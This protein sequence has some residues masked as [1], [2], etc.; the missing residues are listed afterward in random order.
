MAN[1]LYPLG[2]KALLDADIDLLVANIKFVLVDLADYTYSTA[3]D[4]LDDVPGAARVATSANLAGKT[5]TS[6][7]FD[8][9]DVLFTAV[10]GDVSEALIMYVDT[11]TESTSKLIAFF[12]TGVTGLP[13]TPN[14]ENVTIVFNA[15][16]IFS[17]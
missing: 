12:D 7:A 15:S 8:A 2:K 1:A 16:G 14:G 10:T 6:G 3:H 13:I 5:T 11:G 4:N 9:D 17:I